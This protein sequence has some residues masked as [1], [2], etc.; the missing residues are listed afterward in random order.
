LAACVGVAALA[1]SDPSGPPGDPPGLVDRDYAPFDSAMDAALAAQRLPGAVAVVVHRDS[2]IVHLRGYG[3]FAAD[4]LFL[5]AS[6][7]KPIGVGVVMRLA[8]EGRLDVD[9]PIGTY[10]SSA[11]GAG[12]S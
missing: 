11:W 7:S 4:R 8:D 3:A 12:K 5:L 6:A 10:V 9:R 1:C 2:G